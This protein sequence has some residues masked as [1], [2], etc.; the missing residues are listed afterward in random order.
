[1]QEMLHKDQTIALLGLL[2]DLQEVEPLNSRG[3]ETTLI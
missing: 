2:Y 1:M 3:S